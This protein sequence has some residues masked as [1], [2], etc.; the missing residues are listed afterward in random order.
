MQKINKNKQAMPVGRQGFSL[1]E[2]MVTVAIIGIMT[3]V[4]LISMNALREK[5]AVETAASEAQNYALTGKGLTANSPACSFTFVW[6]TPSAT[7]YG[8]ASYT[9][10]TACKVQS[11][12]LKNGV[13][14]SNDG[15]IS[16]SVPFSTTSSADIILSKGSSSY[17]VCVYASGI[18]KE[19]DAC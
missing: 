19:L 12:S 5:K 1:V 18:V 14:F 16:F 3:S 6:A 9:G 11:Y 2:L 13:T 17:H 8:F 10:V 7:D 4:T 15:K